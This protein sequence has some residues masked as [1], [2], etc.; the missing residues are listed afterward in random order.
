[1]TRTGA[2]R[3]QP[4]LELF[5]GVIGVEGLDKKE[6]EMQKRVISGKLQRVSALEMLM[7]DRH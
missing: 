3:R 6:M 5:C 2:E 4:L 7:V 1:M